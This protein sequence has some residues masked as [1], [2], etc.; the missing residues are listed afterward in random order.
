MIPIGG[1][2]TIELERALR[3]EIELY[4]RYIKALK[5]E[6]EAFRKF[7][8]DKIS[9]LTSKRAELV[10]RLATA[11]QKRLDLM[12]RFPDNNKTRLTDM[13][14]LFCH[15][16]DQVVLIPLLDELKMQI[17]LSRKEGY[18]MSS[19]SS[20]AQKVVNGTL[21]IIWSATQNVVASYT[22]KGT[23]EVKYNPNGG[24]DRSVLKQA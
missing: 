18:E 17:A 7:D 10:E 4:K 19:L 14:K 15:P 23:K 5:I 20:F 13:V 9:E 12:G 1:K 11:N 24:R 16:K 21:S 2:L 8:A 22:R 3:A 6:R